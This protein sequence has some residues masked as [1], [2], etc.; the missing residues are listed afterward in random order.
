[1]RTTKR[2]FTLYEF[3]G[4]ISVIPINFEISVL[5]HEEIASLDSLFERFLFEMIDK[6]LIGRI[7]WGIDRILNRGNYYYD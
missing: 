6:R 2:E 3:T 7:E 1:M 5:T 4:N